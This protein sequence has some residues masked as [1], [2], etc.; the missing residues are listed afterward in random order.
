MSVLAIIA[1]L[2]V[3]QWRPLGERKAL[4]G[5]LAAWASWLEQ[6]VNGGERRHGTGAWLGAGLPPVLLAGGPHPGLSSGPG[7]LPPPLNIARLY[8][9]PRFPPFS[10]TSSPI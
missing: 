9:T 3:E 8:L 6:S 5:T 2:V 1:A 7:R 4:Q 10:P